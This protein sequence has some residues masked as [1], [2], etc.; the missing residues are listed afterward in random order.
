MTT[1]TLDIW[2]ADNHLYE[3]VDAYTRHL[4]KQYRSAIQWIQVDGHTKLMIK[5]RLTDTIPNPTYDVIA[6]P[7][8]WADYFRGVNPEGKTLREL[9]K[10]IPCPDAFR[11]AEERLALL[12]SQGVHACV[13]FPT[14]GGMLEERMLDDIELTHAVVHAYNEWLLEDWTFDYQGRIFA[15]PV[16]TLPDVG[17]AVAELDWCVEH[18]ARAVLVNPRPVATA[19]G[20]TTSMGQPCFDLFWNRVQHHGIP[21]LM[22]ACDSGYDRY[23]R[24]WEGAGAEYLPFKPD[25][26]KTIVYEDARSILDTCAALVAHGVFTR[27][28]GVRI[29]VV[30]NGGNWVPRLIGLLEAVYKKMPAEFA[31][32]PIAQFRQHVW[33]NPFHEEDLGGLIDL[34]GAERVL[35]GSDYPHPE[36]LAEPATLTPEIAGLPQPVIERVMGRNLQ[37]LLTAVPHGR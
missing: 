17:K 16:I 8:A 11:R 18:G 33:V 7:G 4:P 34:I 37:E 10:P 32:D 14:T 19:S 24:D 30:E 26:F 27:H 23:S 21:V 1:S 12:D 29:G 5:G 22:H 36:G 3:R 20:H 15:T 2:D 28:P 31:T 6:S 9:A 25:A 35:F 13:M